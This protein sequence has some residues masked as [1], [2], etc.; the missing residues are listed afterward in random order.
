MWS[1]S[2]WLISRRTRNYNC[3]SPDTFPVLLKVMQPRDWHTFF[4]S[5]KD[6]LNLQRCILPSFSPLSLSTP[7]SIM[8]TA[9]LALGKWW[10]FST[11]IIFKL[12]KISKLGETEFHLEFGQFQPNFYQA[13][14]KMS[15][16]RARARKITTKN[17]HENG[18]L[19]GWDSGCFTGCCKSQK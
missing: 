4:W 3:L 19:P 5:S 12:Y 8:K 14:L 17:N 16:L 6:M 7:L 18:G 2:L 1:L 10:A 11:I 9:Q 13:E 15:S